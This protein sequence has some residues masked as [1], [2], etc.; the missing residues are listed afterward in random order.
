MVW[1]CFSRNG[2][3]PFVQIKDTMGRF[4]YKDICEKHML[5]YMRRNMPCGWL[6]QH[7]NDLKHTS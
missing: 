3:G 5:P 7:D 6:F 1:E 4:V 2:V